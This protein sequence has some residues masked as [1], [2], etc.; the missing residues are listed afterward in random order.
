MK[1]CLVA[2]I[3]GQWMWVAVQA[4][5]HWLYV[6]GKPLTL[7]S[8]LLNGDDNGLTLLKFVNYSKWKIVIMSSTERAEAGTENTVFV[9]IVKFLRC[10]QVFCDPVDCSPSGSSVHGISQARVLEWVAISFS[11]GSS[12]PRDQTYGQVDSLPLSHQ[13]SL[14]IWSLLIKC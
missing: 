1:S 10:A 4:I 9:I 6:L 5:V 3:S 11:R 8:L 12:W 2:G 14:S 7:F 13:G